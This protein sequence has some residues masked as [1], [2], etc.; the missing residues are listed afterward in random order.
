MNFIKN[1]HR[2]EKLHSLIINRKTGDP[3]GLAEQLGI[4]RATLYVLIDELN[5]LNMPVAYS[6]KY[7]TFYYKQDVKL[8]LAFKVE[9]IDNPDDLI[10][11]NGGNLTFFLP[12][13]K[14]DGRNLPLYSYFANTKSQLTDF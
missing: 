3:K 8:T 13:E 12:S 1:L 6:R 2:V 4:S 5:S 7:E 14:S 10:K 9:N 11:I